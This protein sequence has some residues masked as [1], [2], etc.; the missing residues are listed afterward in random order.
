MPFTD[1]KLRARALFRRNRVEQELDEELAFHIEREAAKLVEQ[2][3]PPDAALQQARARFGSV[4]VVA[5][6]C[7]DERG[8]AFVDNTVRDV[9]FAFRS[10]AR[11]PLASLTI[12]VTVSLGLGVVA[13]LFTI[14]NTFVFRVDNVPGVDQLY[15]VERQNTPDDVQTIFTRPSFEALRAETNA[16]SDAYAQIPNIDL[17]IE[18]RTAAMAL[19]T[20]NFFDVAGV[21]PVMGR[22]FTADDDGRNGGNAVLVLSDKGWNRRFDR[23]PHVIG[24]TVLIGDVPF[25]I[26][27]V[28][29]ASFRGLEVSA[30]DAWAPLSQVRFFR[31]IE[32]GTEDRVGVEIVGRLKP[33][34]Q[35]A[36]AR[37]QLAAWDANQPGAAV[38]RRAMPIDLV[39]HRGT[40]PQPTEALA[41][42]TPLFLAFGLILLIGCAN[43]ANLLLARGV[44]RQREIGIRLSVGASR[45]RII[46]QLMTESVLLALAAA[47]GGYAV[48][49]VALQQAVYWAM[50]AMPIDIGDV[51]LNV[52][53]ADWRVALFLVIAAIAATAFFAL[54]PALQATR[55]DPVRTLRGELVREARPGRARTAL[56]ALQVFASTLLL[57]CAA[58]FLRSS[59]ASS[60]FDP[61]FRTNDVVMIELINQSKRAAMLQQ[62]ASDPTITAY[63]ATRPNM[64]DQVN[65]FAG[66]ERGKTPVG[67]KFVSGGYFDVMGIPILRGRT[68]TA[69][70]R[71][72]HQVVVLAESVAN[73][74]F[75][76]GEALGQTFRLET[77][78]N[79]QG[80]R[81]DDPPP[82]RLV[83][84]VGISRDIKGFRFTDIKPPGVFLPTSVDTP[85]T[86]LV[87]RVVGAPELARQT[88]LD[89]LTRIDPNMGMIVMMRTVA[90]LEKFLL[91][92]AFWIALV[93]G[94]LALLLTVSGLFSV[95]S[96]LVEQRS[97]EIGIRMALGAR[98]RTVT[99]L[100]LAQTA[101]PVGYGLLAGAALAATLAMLL[102][103]TEFG[104]FIS[105]IVHVADPVAYAASVFVIV[106]ACIAASWLPATRASRL[107]PM[108]TLR[109]D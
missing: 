17:R 16:F 3:V 8:T 97:R 5:D 102:L 68:F 61:G 52:P 25:E 2:G 54:M 35:P 85:K 67:Y 64:L 37:A 89:H 42:F 72:E 91:N 90:T 57:I 108:K 48:S 13:V 107:D 63:A 80:P 84:V 99:Q 93:L 24:K 41:V 30:P 14:L 44:A 11:A 94:A 56:I 75:P 101:R 78:L 28:M 104:A 100:M 82:A 59:M 87:A 105:A 49:R 65:G 9:Q 83:T 58:I 86:D 95:L 74:L 23:D 7:R 70:E 27:G 81:K 98:A 73:T 43:V 34:V 46:R 39:P 55:I 22:V 19:A 40:I 31:P 45:P 109:Q 12:V 51:N 71:D 62:I 4:T 66:T 18:G 1:L 53:A 50:R 38:D 79:E 10:F 6:E 69:A 20:G 76:N 26:V 92:V 77:T 47:A 15:K 32:P 36:S 29:P 21:A 96:Y 60:D 88:L 33:G 103:S 106:I